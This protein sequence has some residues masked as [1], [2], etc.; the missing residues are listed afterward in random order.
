MFMKQKSLFDLLTTQTSVVQEL[1]VY[2]SDE[3]FIPKPRELLML[4]DI[5]SRAEDVRTLCRYL[6]IDFWKRM[7]PR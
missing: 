2:L 4:D 7:G 1:G 6:E 5:R 3:K